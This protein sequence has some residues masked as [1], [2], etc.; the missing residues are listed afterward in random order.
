MADR[1]GPWTKY[2]APQTDPGRKPW[3]KY[4]Q[5]AT[6]KTATG[7]PA[8]DMLSKTRVVSG[9]LLEGIPVVG[10]YLR[11]GVDM[12][13]A[14]TLSL[15]SDKSYD[16]ILKI[17]QQGTEEEKAANPVLDTGSQIGGAVAG[18]IPM[19]MAAPGLM[20][21]GA[22]GLGARMG[23]GAASG[24]VI[25]GADSAVRS[26][27]DPEAIK[28]GIMYGGIGGLAGPAVGSIIGAGARKAARVIQS[29]RSGASNRVLDSLSADN[30][31]V[32]EAS[33]RLQELGPNGMIADLGPNLRSDA[34]AIANSPGAGQKV[35]RST[36]EERMS[37]A[38]ARI[39]AE[40]DASL[41]PNADIAT[42]RDTLIAA[43]AEK[44][45]PLFDQAFSEPYFV[46]QKQVNIL[47]TP[48][49]R[50]AAAK[51]VRMA[52]NEGVE[53][54]GDVRTVH[55]VKMALD[56]Q[57][58][59]AQRAGKANEARILTKM[60]NSF[61]E[62]MPESYKKAL[63]A[64][65]GDS[66][67]IDALESGQGLFTKN[68]PAG[69]IRAD[70]AKMSK[71]ERDLFLKGARSQ[72]EEMMS[73]SANDALAMRKLF[74][75]EGAR[76]K[77][78]LVL[79]KEKAGQFMR[80]LMR[81]E[82]FATT[83]YEVMGNSKTAARTAA[84]ARWGGK[85]NPAGALE[86]AGNL[87]FGSAVKSVLGRAGSGAAE[88]A[89]AAQRETAARLLSGRDLT[90]L[91]QL[92]AISKRGA[93]IGDS[94]GT[95]AQLGSVNAPRIATQRQNAPLEITVGRKR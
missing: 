48:A 94:L 7:L 52:Q 35:V 72:L 22:G 74:R 55:M 73:N 9:G 34:A 95:L 70:F 84:Q 76:R 79:G 37:G 40:A 75:Q 56:D 24:A 67:M 47:K 33:R 58:A 31:T 46:N 59:I 15:F 93:F 19:V 54:T 23:A 18:T 3:E 91:Q 92:E 88:R 80:S 44:A 41:G 49:G 65:A 66:A 63:G 16:E 77:L 4:G 68:T 28:R 53:L 69:Q 32:E 57:I 10:P 64:Y 90:K 17:I 25:G 83:A 11:E 62:G 60:K 82:E 36:L 27:G 81:E 45:K 1:V 26:D 5:P 6:P 42:Q 78:D 87:Q 8:D 2:A 30:M 86:Q 89:A 43:R 29:P 14:G 20:G 21:A 38:P 13:A 61:V 71:G 85:G 51:A 12:A 39:K 50:A